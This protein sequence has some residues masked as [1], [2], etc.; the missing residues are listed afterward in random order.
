VTLRLPA[1]WHASQRHRSETVLAQHRAG[2]LTALSSRAAAG[3]RTNL[4]KRMSVVD[5]MGASGTP[6][7]GHGHQLYLAPHGMGVGA[8]AG[9]GTPGGATRL[10][11]AGTTSTSWAAPHA[12]HPSPALGRGVEL[13]ARTGSVGLGAGDTKHAS[14]THPP[15]GMLMPIL[16]PEQ[17]A[18]PHTAVTLCLVIVLRQ[19]A[20][21]SG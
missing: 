20:F 19:I 9:V 5:A 1:A 17:V 13:Q 8:N 2:E 14:A 15:T 18:G 7:A 21:L 3:L 16:T 4:S 6:R 10:E 12:H 11:A